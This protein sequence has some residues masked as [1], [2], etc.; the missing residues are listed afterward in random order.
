MNEEKTNE[1]EAAHCY[2]GPSSLPARAVCPC[3]VGDGGSA[4]AESGTRSHKVVEANLANRQSCTPPEPGLM[5]VTESPEMM[6][7]SPADEY[8]PGTTED[9]ISRGTWGAKKI[10]ELRDQTA[11]GAYIYTEKRV[12]FNPSCALFDNGT[13]IA[14]LLGV[15]GTVDAH[16]I[17]D[18]GET[19][20]I[21]DYKTYSRSDGEK[22]YQPQGKAYAVLIASNCGMNIRRAVFFCVCAGDYSVSRYDFT[23]DAAVG[24]TVRTIQAARAALPG[25]LFATGDEAREKCGKPSVWCDHCKFANDC[26]AI[27][28]A[29]EVVRNNG[30]LAKPLA[31]RM[32]VTPILE[33]FIKSTKEAVKIELD[34]G[35]RVWD[36][37]SGIEYAY[38][39]R[40]ANA[41]LADIKG[42]ATAVVGYG[43]DP[44]AFAEIVKCS[45][46]AVDGLLK[47]VDEAAG[48]KV[49]K[50]ER[51]AIY[52]PYY[53]D[54][55]FNR[56]VKRIS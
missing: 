5:G 40:K 56:Y 26:P 25:F 2:F 46:T 13:G 18:N 54:A 3:Y 34:A 50:A 22:D 8:A 33:A 7:V 4:V 37:E 28:R 29:V 20:Y 15:F 10:Q 51:E 41:K 21:A 52:T 24:E 35:R 55:G 11:P 53:K 45:K 39:E 49:K 1:Q 43:V 47:A 23:I 32:A 17:G 42:L 12:K 48:R 9:E 19:L 44:A 6:G 27:S 14:E 38:S 30:I 36:A 16:W 31:V